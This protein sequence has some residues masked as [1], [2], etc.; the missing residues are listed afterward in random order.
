MISDAPLRDLVQ[1]VGQENPD[2]TPVITHIESFPIAERYDKYKHMLEFLMKARGNL[3]EA[4]AKLYQH[5]V[6]TLGVHANIPGIEDSACR[7]GSR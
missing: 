6:T 4:I 7:E 3:D 5:V 2:L 1:S